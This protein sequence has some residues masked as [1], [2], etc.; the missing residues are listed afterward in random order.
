MFLIHASHDIL[1]LDVIMEILV[2]HLSAIFLESEE[3]QQ[4]FFNVY[5]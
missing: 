4:L 3:N 2:T 1:V 5:W